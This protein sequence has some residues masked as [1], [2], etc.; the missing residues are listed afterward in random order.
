MKSIRDI[1]GM[2]LLAGLFL[3]SFNSVN[4]QVT[5]RG[6]QADDFLVH[7]S[8]GW[9]NSWR[10]QV[11]EGTGA[12]DVSEA[13]DA[14]WL[15]V[16]YRVGGGAWQH[17]S[18]NEAGHFHPAGT[19]LQAGLQDPA[20]ARQ[21]GGNPIVGFFLYRDGSGFGDFSAESVKLSLSYSENGLSHDSSFEIR[22]FAVEMEYI[23]GQGVVSAVPPFYM[24]KHEI[25]QQQFVDFLNTLEPAKQRLHTTASPFASEGSPAIQVGDAHCNDIQ[26]L[27]PAYTLESRSFPAEY[28]TTQPADPCAFIN[29]ESAAAFLAWS[30]QRSLSEQELEVA[31]SWILFRNEKH[32]R[33]NNDMILGGSIDDNGLAAGYRGARSASPAQ[34]GQSNPTTRAQL[35]PPKR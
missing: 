7:F 30:G 9:E 24:M 25:T 6:E 14:A 32:K 1:A 31:E 28:L 29:Q 5:P 33:L 13:W 20:S 17:A 27:F 34:G 26:V 22:L 3:F 35:S 11:S 23:P 21:V 15:F 16:K 4:G 19:S 8:I 2:V 12:D 18:L 10:G